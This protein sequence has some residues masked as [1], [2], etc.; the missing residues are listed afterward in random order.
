MSA[1]RPAPPPLSSRRPNNPSQPPFAPRP[2]RGSPGQCA[3]RQRPPQYDSGSGFVR[4][5]LYVFAG[6][7]VLVGG[8]VGYLMINPPSELIRRA[9]T[10]Q[11]KAKT[12][13]D[14]VVAGPASFTLYPG[15][16][17]SL[18][19]VS[20]AGPEGTEQTL[21]T[22]ESLDVSVQA[23]PLFS[24]EI[25]VDRL[26]LRKPVFDLRIDKAGKKNWDLT[27]LAAPIRYAQAG[28]S[29]GIGGGRALPSRLSDVKKLQLG[30]VGIEDGVIRFSD[31][32]S[33]TAQQV[34]AVNVRVALPALDQP[35]TAKGS[36]GWRGEQTAFEATLTDAKTV[37]EEK[38]AALKVKT[39]N[40]YVAASFEGN[41][42]FAEGAD[43]DGHVAARSDSA[44]AL[45]Q[46]LGNTLPPVT[47]FGPLSVAG[48]LKTAGNVTNL[49]N[50]N[51][52]LDGATATGAVTVTTGGVR[53]YVTANLDLAEL[54]LNKYLTRAAVSEDAPG[55]PASSQE[56][57][58]APAA[59]PAPNGPGEAD[60]I[61]QLL[62][63]PKTKVYGATHRAGWS[64]EPFN[65]ALLAIAD[66][67][68]KLQIGRLLFQDM[69]IGKSASTV[70]LKNRQLAV[71]FDDIR[72]YEGRGKGVVTVDGTGAAA[73]IGANLAL[74]NI[75]ALPFLKDAAKMGWLAGRSTLNLQLAATGTNQ[76]Q[77]V[78][79][80]NGKAS[81]AFNNGAIV[82]FN[83]PGAIRGLSQGNFG[84]FKTAPTEKTDFS[85]LSATFNI[86]K[87]VA[88]NQDLQLV[89]PLLRVTGAGA[90]DLPPR[91]VDYTVKP[92]LVASLEGQESSSAVSGIEV[93]VRI[94]GSWERP[95]F[96]PDLKGV[97]SDPSKTIEA[98]KEIGKQFKGKNA[99][100]I[101]DDLFGKK[102]GDAG[103]N[104]ET[105]AKAKELLNKLFKQ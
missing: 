17:V 13:R 80:L 94:S 72:L 76:L 50:A 54:N 73:G 49:S 27:Q 10:E 61:E 11:V 32:R 8:A 69:K 66:A 105:K 3:S 62:N 70:A 41:V 91:T 36:V 40:R 55:A 43:L 5:L 48:R 35:I 47:G 99:S 96:E 25:T 28:V 23:V 95:K 100:E 33:G 19:E 15:L 57:S 2:Q 64:S 30:D 59:A 46:W 42:R 37:L 81:V 88:Q 75:A 7:V 85:Q 22:M 101:V 45:A 103:G 74:D 6:L 82:G 79:S 56:R 26:V 18:S 53:P 38:P 98:V 9:I 104:S 44:R 16:G 4:G 20:L 14:L 34:D 87:G 31:D 67:D 92:K 60:Q 52:G 29:V 86:S 58:A 78:E 84:G 65:L 1:D 102:N 39:T 89:S 77:L 90:V 71:T 93:P 51:F 63:E 21:V 12:G 24:S 83:L 97:L 68:A